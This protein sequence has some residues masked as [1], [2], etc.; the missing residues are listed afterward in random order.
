MQRLPWHNEY[1]LD[2][3]RVA[4]ILRSDLA[5]ELTVGHVEPLGEGWD[6]TTFLVDGEWVFRFP[7][8]RQ[9]ARQLAR[10]RKL[11]A[12]LAPALAN[13]P[14]AIPDYRFSISTPKAFPLA[15]VGYRVLRG[16]PLLECDRDALDHTALGR[17]LGAFLARLESAAPSPRPRIYYDPFPSDW[18]EFRHEL[19]D[20]KASLPAPIAAA[21]ERLLAT[22]PKP[23]DAPP[24]FGHCDLG[25]EHILVDTA[26]SRI[27]AVID[28]GD[29]GWGN[30]VADLVG[31]WAWGGDAAVQSTLPTWGH[32]LSPDDWI[33]LR[34]WGVAY[35]IGSAYYGYKDRRERLH[36]T[37]LGWLDRMNCYGQLRDPATPD[38]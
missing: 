31:L 15:Y 6:F 25:A 26:N 34:L 18:I 30:R 10:E 38:R 22:T 12:A 4:A 2:A 28:W 13:Q 36:A 8:R 32:V 7:K 16:T 33:R 5:G 24:L 35:A 27:T 3:D 17:Q 19:S 29:A 20:A 21:C 37:A 23:D 14:I 1:P 9:S 11:L